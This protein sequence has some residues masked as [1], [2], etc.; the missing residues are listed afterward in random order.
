M[1]APKYQDR[2]HNAG[3]DPRGRMIKSRTLRMSLSL[4]TVF[5]LM[6]GCSGYDA[7]TGL[8]AKPTGGAPATLNMTLYS[9]AL[10]CEAEF[11]RQHNLAAPRVAVGRISDLTGKY[12]L[13]SGSRIGEGASLYALTALGKGGF[14]VVERYDT[15]VSDIELKYA[16]A[17]VL[18]DNPDAAGQDSDNFRK[19]YA[20]QIA[21]SDYYIVGGVTQLD[22]NI[23]S[24]GIDAALGAVSAK[25]PKGTFQKRRYVMNV[26]VDL[27]LVNTRSQEV[28]DMV[29]YQKQVIGHEI[30][31]GVFDFLNGTVVDISGGK[32]EAEP[33]N[34]AV[35]TLVERS[36][37]EFGETLYGFRGDACLNGAPR[38]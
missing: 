7:K 12:D 23:E 2:L 15:A 21:G 38:D 11:A 1:V 18:S 22:Y 27:R 24:D 9:R 28:V 17:R 33:L 14:R 32:S 20:G 19:V 36:I 3:P 30:K 10:G 5:C 26:A 29:S 35:R 31:A 34:L 13:E 8:Y 6:A 16:M 37:F 4:G 25:D